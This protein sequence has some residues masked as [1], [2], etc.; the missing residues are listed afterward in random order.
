MSQPKNKQ[1]ID[2]L[3]D[4]E[5]LERVSHNNKKRLLQGKKVITLKQHSYR[6]INN[7]FAFFNTYS[8][9]LHVSGS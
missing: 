5:H 9:Q 8:P 1:V 2:H 7:D 4:E 3:Y 6:S